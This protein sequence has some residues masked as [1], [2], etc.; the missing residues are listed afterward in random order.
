MDVDEHNFG[1]VYVFDFLNGNHPIRRSEKMIPMAKFLQIL[2][3]SLMIV[4]FLTFQIRPRD[5]FVCI[6]TLFFYYLFFVNE[7]WG[8]WLI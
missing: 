8:R 3:S 4:N 2:S 7:R 6:Y 5:T 1:A